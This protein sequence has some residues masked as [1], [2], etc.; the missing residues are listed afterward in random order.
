MKLLGATLTTLILA[1]IFPAFLPWW[2]I[3]AA[4]F[5]SALLFLRTGK[6]AFLSGFLGVFILWLVLNLIT[7]IRNNHLLSSKIASLLPLGG[8]NSFLL[9]LM[10]SLIGGIVGGMAALGAVYLKAIER[11]SD[12]T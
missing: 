5:I 3:A 7:D 6:E 12:A 10:A 9:L 4:A 1:Y 11:N 8:H 2:S